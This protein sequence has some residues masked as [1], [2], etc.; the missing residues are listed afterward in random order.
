[1]K[2]TNFLKYSIPKKIEKYFDPSSLSFEF[3]LKNSKKYNLSPPT[4]GLQK[5]FTEYII[6]ENSDKKKPN[7]SFLKVIPFLLY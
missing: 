7:L 5:S 4:I 2:R 1:M 6:K 3:T